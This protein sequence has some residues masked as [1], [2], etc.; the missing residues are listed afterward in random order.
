MS[1]TANKIS[2]MRVSGW[3]VD[4]W[5]GMD[6]RRDGIMER[7]EM[8]RIG[9]KHYAF[10]DTYATWKNSPTVR[11]KCSHLEAQRRFAMLL[12]TRKMMN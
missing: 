3:V 12:I 7:Y 6:D 5:S 11:Y 4:D 2:G 10:Y 1:T 9:K 8:R